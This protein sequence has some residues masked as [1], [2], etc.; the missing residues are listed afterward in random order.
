[1]RLRSLRTILALLV[2]STL[3]A[4]ADSF[5]LTWPNNTLTFNLSISDAFIDSDE[6]GTDE[7]FFFNID[8]K[9]NSENGVAQFL[10]FFN[11]DAP[12]VLLFNAVPPLFDVADFDSDDALW[13]GPVDDPSF[14]L[15]T[16]A[17]TFSL[18]GSAATLVIAP[19]SSTVPEPSTFAL[20]ATGILGL[21]GASWRRLS[22]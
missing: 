15:G 19:D 17:G 3:Y 16:H 20:L 1:M 9:L 8:M 11:P 14:V 10:A 2:A 22:H 4:K 21:A 12:S 5:T 13:G 18:N 6:H 7:L